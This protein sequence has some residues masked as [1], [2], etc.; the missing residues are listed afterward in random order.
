MPSNL[1]SRESKS[2]P[3]NN[4]SHIKRQ[5]IVDHA[6][7]DPSHCL[8]DGLF[9]PLL[10]GTRTS[11]ALDV[12]YRHKSYTFHW[13]GS[14]LLSIGDQSIF[15]AIHR[16]A[17]QKG[18]PELVNTLHENPAMTEVRTAL[19]MAYEASDLGCLVLRTTPNEI[20]KTTGV[21]LSGQAKT[22]IMDSLKRLS[23]VS[24]SIYRDAL[25][26][27]PFW[28]ANLISIIVSDGEIRIGINPML[29]KATQEA[30]ST[31][32]DMREQRA[33]KSDVSKRLHLWL[34]S[35][36]G[37]NHTTNERSI[38]I[39]LLIPHIWGDTCIGDALYGRRKM[40]KKAINEMNTLTGWKCIVHAATEKL[41]IM[42]S[43]VGV[44]ES[45]T[46]LKE[47]T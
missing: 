26:Q 15:L 27:V 14:E 24:F 7:I 12:R 25:P 38:N 32:I 29:S 5:I 6:R 16:L 45:V 10:R 11:A 30:P 44:T 41:F 28:E 47:L 9:K 40:L 33:L 19:D 13:C 8:A 31:F 42:R 34:S 3:S 35:W 43:P 36:I 21:K 20:A 4:I 39:D 37:T 17:A 22:R 1:K 2:P 18:R 23:E 46:S